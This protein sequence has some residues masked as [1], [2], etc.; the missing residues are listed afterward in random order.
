MSFMGLQAANSAI[1]C[2]RRMQANLNYLSGIADRP[3]K[4]ADKIPIRPAIMQ[5]IAADIEG[6]AMLPS[7]LELLRH[8]YAGLR[9]LWPS[10]DAPSS[11]S[12][13][14]GKT[15]DAAATKTVNGAVPAKVAGVKRAPSAALA[16]AKQNAKKVSMAA[17]A[18]IR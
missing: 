4:P 17:R 14:S 15:S 9:R 18:P 12:S 16:A 5:P 3:L 2:M 7:N 13:S 6:N 8:L 10:D 11:S 1:R